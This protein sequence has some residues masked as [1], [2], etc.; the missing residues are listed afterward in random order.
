VETI[1]LIIAVSGVLVALIAIFAPFIFNT[2]HKDLKNNTNYKQ[3]CIA[4]LEGTY[5]RAFRT[6]YQQ[7][8]EAGLVWLNDIFG[9]PFSSKALTI[10]TGLAIVY[11][12]LLFMF[13]WAL[14]G[15]GNIGAIQVL[16]E[17]ASVITRLWAFSFL[18]ALFLIFI[19]HKKIDSFF[20]KLLARISSKTSGTWIYRIFVALIIISISIYFRHPSYSPQSS[21][22]FL[23]GRIWTHL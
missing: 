18:I 12:I 10:N 13:S 4:E 23:F 1:N 21:L 5:V 14:G 20:K 16:P 11:A 19:F 8:L 7:K 2:I 9:S 17:V 22:H 6:F 3:Q 15:S